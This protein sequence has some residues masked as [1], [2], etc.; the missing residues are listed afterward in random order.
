MIGFT[1]WTTPV[2]GSRLGLMTEIHLLERYEKKK[3]VP[4]THNHA[5]V[6]AFLYVKR[7][8]V[9]CSKDFKENIG[10]TGWRSRVRS[11]NSPQENDI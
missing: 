4:L 9:V 10:G 6:R 1:C 3:K 8:L 5:L 2:G 7:E 11:R